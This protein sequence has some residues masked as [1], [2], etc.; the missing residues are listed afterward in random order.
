VAAREEGYRRRC[1]TL[2]LWP[3]ISAAAALQTVFHG[4]SFSFFSFSIGD[5]SLRTLF[6]EHVALKSWAFE[7]TKG[8]GSE[9]GEKPRIKLLLLAIGSGLVVY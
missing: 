9:V 1:C 4:V 7:A 5:C 8:A 3:T 2:L 6:T